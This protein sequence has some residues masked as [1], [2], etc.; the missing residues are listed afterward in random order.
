MTAAEA[1]AGLPEWMRPIV[2]ACSDDHS[3][4]WSSFAMPD[5]VSARESAVLI[6]FGETDGRPDLLLTGRSQQLRSHPGQAAFPGGRA[7]PGDADAAATALREAAEETGLD[8]YGV[9]V[10]ASLPPL[11]L[12]HS[13]HVVTPVVGWWRDPS[14]VR[15]V[16]LAE[17]ASVHRIPIDDLL[18]PAHRFELAYPGG[19]LGAA[20][21][22]DGLLIWGFTALLLSALFD[23]AGLTKPWDRTQVEDFPISPEVRE[24]GTGGP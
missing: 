20:F 21:R 12:R 11:W 1:P 7:E 10:V 17:V 13:D 4:A 18:D 15:P 19:R 6:L 9:D 5:D 8:P 3:D 2:S 16:D 24:R 14:P 23:V 22:A